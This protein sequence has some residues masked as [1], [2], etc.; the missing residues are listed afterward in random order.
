MDLT[1]M[2]M[3][4]SLLNREKAAHKL[5]MTR[6]TRWQICPLMQLEYS[7][8]EQ[9]L[10]ALSLSRRRIQGVEAQ[11]MVRLRLRRFHPDSKITH[12]VKIKQ[13]SLRATISRVRTTPLKT[14]M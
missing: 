9:G 14:G 11:G 4:L 2:K 13:K 8:S 6:R 7:I 5:L 12:R 1:R 10:P 3:E